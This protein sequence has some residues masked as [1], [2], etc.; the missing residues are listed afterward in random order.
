MIGNMMTLEDIEEGQRVR[1]TQRIDDTVLVVEGRVEDE[2]RR[3]EF[4]NDDLGKDDIEYEIHVHGFWANYFGSD[5]V[6]V[7]LLG[8]KVE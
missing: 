6:T 2:V 1:I 3:F 5:D 4:H 8:D 7:L